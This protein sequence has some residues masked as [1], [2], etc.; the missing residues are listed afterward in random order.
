MDVRIRLSGACPRRSSTCT[1]RGS[2][3]PEMLMRLAT[4]NRVDIPFGSVE[5]IRAAYRFGELQDFLDIYYQGMNVL[6]EEEDFHDLAMA[7]LE[8]AAA[9]GIVHVEVFYDPPGP[10]RARHPLRDRDRRNPGRARGRT[11]E[12]RHHVAAD[13]LHPAPPARGGRLRHLSR[14]RALDR[15]PPHLRARTRFDRTGQSA[16]QVRAPVRRGPRG[17]AQAGR[18]CRRGGS[19]RLRRR[20]GGSARG[21][22]RIDHGNRALEDPALVRRLAERGIT[23]HRVS[24]VQPPALRGHGPE[25]APAQANARFEPQGHRQLRRSSLFRRLPAGQLRRGRRGA[26][27]WASR[28]SWLWSET[29]SRGSFLDEPARRAHLDRIERTVAPAR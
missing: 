11:R 24:A 5:E 28:I 12:A 8:R 20:R 7:Y 1:W 15:R 19:R 3:E 16:R 29:R 21:S 2:L 23:P 6:R 10:H 22:N 25:A 26:G 18:P 13:P 4:R 9:D 17:R 14:G 27:G